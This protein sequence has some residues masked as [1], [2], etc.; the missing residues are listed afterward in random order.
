M[1]GSTSP[2]P[3]NGAPARIGVFPGPFLDPQHRTPNRWYSKIDKEKRAHLRSEGWCVIDDFC[4]NGKDLADGNEVGD[5]PGTTGA[6]LGETLGDMSLSNNKTQTTSNHWA[7]ALRSEIAWL[8]TSGRLGPNRTHFQN[9]Q[10]GTRFLFAKPNVFEADLHDESIRATVPE[11]DFFFET[12]KNTLPRAFKKASTGVGTGNETQDENTNDDDEFP[13][14]DFARLASG[15]QARTVKV[16]HNR[17]KGGCFPSHYDNPGG[18]SKRFLT[19]I[20]YLNPIWTE[21][22]GGE[23][24]VTPFLRAPVTIQPKHDRLAVFYS[25]RVLHSVNGFNGTDRF[26]LTVWLDALAGTVNLPQHVAL[27]LNPEDVKGGVEVLATKLL[28]RPAQRSVSRAVYR[29]EY[30]A[31]LRSCMEGH[32]GFEEMR[33]SHESTVERFKANKPLWGLVEQLRK[34]KAFREMTGERVV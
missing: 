18:G 4:G 5:A 33:A 12:V 16:Q 11:L 29:E 28:A 34:V 22:D 9:Q 32:P 14:P 6:T 17:G 27:K 2:P 8:S 31:S 15:D 1:P 19:C 10:S 20:L 25:D 7:T 24:V 21:G 13:F 3:A 23:L 26:C 30:L